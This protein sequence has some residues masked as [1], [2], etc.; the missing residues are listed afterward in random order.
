[1]YGL[2]C[3][4]SMELACLLLGADGADAAT[5]SH[6]LQ[7]HLNLPSLTYGWVD[8]SALSAALLPGNIAL[9]QRKL[10]VLEGWQE[11]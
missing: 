2:A 7:C 11:R 1:M 5:C 9:R 4:S 10:C 3:L 8:S 6:L